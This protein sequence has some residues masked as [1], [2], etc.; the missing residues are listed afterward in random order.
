M[1]GWGVQKDFYIKKAETNKVRKLLIGY[2]L[3]SS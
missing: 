2:R 3:N 1:G